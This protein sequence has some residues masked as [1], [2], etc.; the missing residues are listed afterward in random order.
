M[1]NLELAYMTLFGW[2]DAKRALSRL[3]AVWFFLLSETLLRRLRWQP[4]HPHF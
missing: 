3:F 2:F 4:S 1:S